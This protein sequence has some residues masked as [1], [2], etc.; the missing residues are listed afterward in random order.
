AAAR[1]SGLLRCPRASV[2]VVDSI[3]GCPQCRQPRPRIRANRRRAATRLT[4]IDLRSDPGFVGIVGLVLV[5]R[6]PGGRRLLRWGR[7]VRRWRGVGPVFL[8]P[9]GWARRWGGASGSVGRGDLG[10]WASA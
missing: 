10:T 8:Q 6:P 3:H 2:L 4:R 5:R 1:R 7:L 9:R